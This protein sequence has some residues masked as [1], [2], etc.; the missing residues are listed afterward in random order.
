MIF[1]GAT[2]CA[3]RNIL[4]KFVYKFNVSLVKISRKYSNVQYVE[5]NRILNNAQLVNRRL[6]LKY[7]FKKLVFEHINSTI[8]TNMCI[9]YDNLTLIK[10]RETDDS[11]S[12]NLENDISNNSQCDS[13]EIIVLTSDNENSRSADDSPTAFSSTLWT[14]RLTTLLATPR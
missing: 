5:T 6:D 13:E 14:T 10:C 12:K 11:R 3:N 9:N 7:V 8:I 1:I 4:N 2:Y